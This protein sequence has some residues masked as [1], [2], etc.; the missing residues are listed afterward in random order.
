M[1]SNKK[2]LSVFMGVL[3]STFFFYI[4]ASGG[5]MLAGNLLF[6]SK[7][8]GENTYIGPYDVSDFKEPETVKVL[9]DGVTDL[10]GRFDVNIVYQDASFQLP[11]EA[12]S[13]DV[14]GTIDNASSGQE[15]PMLAQVN[16]EAVRTLLSQNFGELSF[17]EQELSSITDGIERRLR[18]GTMPA[19]IQITDFMDANRLSA[20]DQVASTTFSGQ[21]VS[22]G[23]LNAMAALDGYLVEAGSSVSFIQMLESTENGTLTEAEMTRIASVLYATVLN[24]NFIID[25]RSISD[26]LP[27]GIPVGYEAAVNISTGMDFKFTNPNGS[28]F[29]IRTDVTGDSLTVALEGLPL[30][31]DYSTSVTGLENFDPR[32]IKQFSENVRTASPRIDEEGEEG[33]RVT[34]L[35]HVSAGSI[36]QSVEEVSTDFYAP[37]HRIEVHR[38]KPKEQPA[39][40]N[41]EGK[42]TDDDADGSDSSETS[43]ENDDNGSETGSGGGS[44]ENTGGSGNTGKGSDEGSTDDGDSNQDDSEEIIY[45]K[46]GNPIEP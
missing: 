42:E 14:D 30:M 46:G 6:P 10:Q 11:Q 27:E 9:S 45:D 21:P 32:T 17:T 31:Y 7:D 43:E 34:V 18:S 5:S 19:N 23:L 29:T 41:G 3:A 1:E 28:A 15:N 2:S 35:K 37:V 20:A 39:A 26:R 33:V 40:E 13:Y 16:G 38:L 4:F 22:N 36:E 24:T 8:F 44:T 25:E 12:V